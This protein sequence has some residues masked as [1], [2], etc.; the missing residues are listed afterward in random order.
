MARVLMAVCL[1]LS[2]ASA[3]S[4]TAQQPG[5][6]RNVPRVTAEADPSEV[7]V[8][9][10]FLFN[11]VMEAEGR[12]QMRILK[13]P[14]FGSL[15]ALA[16]HQGT[17]FRSVNGR[18]QI[19]YN[20]RFTLQATT[21]GTVTVSGGIALVDGKQVKIPPVKIKVLPEG[22]K[23]KLPQGKNKDLFMDGSVDAESPY[24]GQQVLLRYT[25]Y[26]DERTVGPFGVDVHDA[27]SPS[28]D[29]FWTEDMNSKIRARLSKK[30]MD[31]R[32]YAVK[33]VHILAIF[34][35]NTGDVTIEPMTMDVSAS[36]RF[37][38]RRNQKRLVSNPITLKVRDLPAGAPKGFHKSNVGQFRFEATVDKRRV[39][40]GEPFTVRLA[41]EGSGMVG[42]VK[43]PEIQPQKGWRV[44]DPVFEKQTG[45]VNNKILGGRKTAE[46]VITPSQEGK[47]TIPPLAFHYFDPY[48]EA[49]KTLRSK[50]LDVLVQ[51]QSQVKEDKEEEKVVERTQVG[52]SS[53]LQ[54]SQEPLQPL[55][56]LSA[57]RR[58]LSPS[59]TSPWFWGGTF[60][61][62]A[63]WLGWLLLGGLRARGGEERRAAREKKKA[64]GEAL[65]RLH[66]ASHAGS[67]SASCREMDGAIVAYLAQALDVPTGS[68]SSSR[69]KRI[70]PEKGV[71]AAVVDRLLELRARCDKGRF[72][73]E[74]GVDIPGMIQ[75]AREVL[76]TIGRAL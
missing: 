48:E 43:F 53:A 31:N 32:A 8:G 37:G 56:S 54:T 60:L 36:Q 23:P 27:K 47:L 1:A 49:Y 41:V 62:P 2:L 65:D 15:Q 52:P 45:T 11:V 50:P 72:G 63:L 18:S 16:S 14:D 68:V 25:L 70:L 61:P 71:D 33:P 17:E 20:Q 42:R 44:L 67:V 55:K 76:Q 39:A 13:A 10:R 28:F 73:D 21:E 19:A 30:Y 75:E 34:P 59:W 29:G 38:R 64:P 26:Y 9:D 46:I 6:T 4:A 58:D 12:A 69:L 3:T 66:N 5:A 51:G 57:E 40:A 74:E 35:L 24:V 22:K 7:S